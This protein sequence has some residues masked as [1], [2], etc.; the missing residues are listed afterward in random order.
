MDGH[1]DKV[2]YT[3]N[4]QW[5]KE[6]RKKKNYKERYKNKKSRNFHKNFV[7]T[8]IKIKKNHITN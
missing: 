3:V 7:L 1:T 6:E 5:S 8:T 4:V 2:N